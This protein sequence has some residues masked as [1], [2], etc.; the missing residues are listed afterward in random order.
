MKNMT[1][2]IFH[3]F[4]IKFQN[5]VREFYKRKIKK[6]TPIAKSSM[7]VEY[8]ME[9][10]DYI[11]PKKKNAVTINWIAPQPI[12]GSGGHRNIYRIVHYL[13]SQGYNVTM[14]I[15]PQDPNNPEYVKSG[16]EAY[17]KIKDNFFDL[18]CSIVYGVDHIEKCD[19]LFATHYDSAYI[20]EANKNKAKLCCYFIQDY[21]CYFNPMSYQY[22]KAYN[23]YNMGLYP[24]T[25]G[26]WPLRLLERDFGVKEGMY[27][28][29]PIDRSIYYVDSKVKKKQRIVFFAKPYMPRRCYQL[30]VEALEIVKEK[31]PEWEI[32]FYGSNPA[33]YANVPFEFTNFGLVPTICE[34][35][36]LYR[37]S[38]I[39]IAFSTTNPSLVPYEMMSCGAAVVDLDFNDSVV[40]YDSAKN[41]SLAK[42][43]KEGVAKAVI[44]LIEDEKKLEKQVQNALVFCEKFPSEKEMCEKIER[45]I[46]KQLKKTRSR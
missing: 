4:P 30:G 41:I 7:G 1:K 10:K 37:S 15:D 25:S 5:R 21:E 38:R 13:S 12:I 39:G 27:F 23:T 29:F 36:D 35:G 40:S 18:G 45:N 9:R 16:Y 24:V 42:P 43:T 2:K 19:I 8:P 11:L 44:Q 32:V 6:E 28:R 26:P 20:V 34:L 17:Q 14:Y 46:L 31:H 22:L 3:L 33:D